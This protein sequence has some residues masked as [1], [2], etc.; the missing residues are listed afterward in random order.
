MSV[1]EWVTRTLCGVSRPRAA[2]AFHMSKATHR[3]A[4]E[5]AGHY[6]YIP[7]VTYKPRDD[8]LHGVPVVLCE[9]IAP[10]VIVLEVELHM[11]G[12]WDIHA[13]AFFPELVPAPIAVAVTM[14]DVKE[15]ARA[16]VLAGGVRQARRI[17]QSFGVTKVADLG[18]KHL[19][20]C[21]A[22]MDAARKVITDG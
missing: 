7:P 18:P 11:P 14:E 15:S 9:R 5:S 10:G 16:L 2:A 17:V 22:Q 1:N 13:A 19:A 3:A 20:Q 21:A 8:S 6:V 4:C 12:R